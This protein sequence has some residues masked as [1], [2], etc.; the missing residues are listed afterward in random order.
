[1]PPQSA[2]EA[3][4]PKLEPMAFRLLGEGRLEEGARLLAAL[5]S[6]LESRDRAEKALI[7]QDYLQRAL[8]R[9]SPPGQDLETYDR[10]R[11]RWLPRIHAIAGSLEPIVLFHELLYEMVEVDA[12]SIEL[13]TNPLIRRA[14]NYID[15]HYQQKI[16]LS[17]VADHLH[18]S[19]N[20][21]SRLFRQESGVTLTQHIQRTRLEHAMLLL[22]D[23][24]KSISEIAYLVGYQNY[25]DFYRNFVKYENAAP[26][27]VRQRFSDLGD[28]RRAN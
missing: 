20:Y 7:L 21:L 8:R 23:G 26:R 4:D 3:Q 5:A 9:V 1:M 27:Q 2:S 19:P 18:V 12:E 13:T 15:E 17:A 22:A 28:R 14:Q 16:S 25:R 10:A 24:E 6:G 11:D